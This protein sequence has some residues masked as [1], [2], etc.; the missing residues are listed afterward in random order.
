MLRVR[1]A[2][3]PQDLRCT[4]STA[5]AGP[6]RGVAAPIAALRPRQGLIRAGCSVKTGCQ[7][8]YVFY[9]VEGDASKVEVRRFTKDGAHTDTSGAVCHGPNA[10]T[11]LP[12]HQLAPRASKAA[13]RAAGALY[14]L[15]VPPAR[16]LDELRDAVAADKASGG[17][18]GFNSKDATLGPKWLQ[19]VITAIDQGRYCTSS[20]DAESVEALVTTEFPESVHLYDRLVYRAPTALLAERRRAASYGASSSLAA[21]APAA[22]AGIQVTVEQ[23]FRLALATPRGL[24]ALLHSGHQQPVFMDTTFGTNVHG[25]RVFGDAHARTHAQAHAHA[26][27]LP[28]GGPP[29]PLSAPPLPPSSLPPPPLPPPTLLHHH[30]LRHRFLLLRPS[31]PSAPVPPPPPLFSP[32]PHRLL[33]RT[34]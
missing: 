2:S 25:V 8:A 30:P 12:M 20:N 1:C 15:G 28:G 3:G 22:A 9:A 31:A 21:G 14:S 16:I 11:A 33:A 13:E 29:S 24:S 19:N 18:G 6:R 27:L 26:S 5:P 7:A 10:V 32:L 23:Q 17:G 4:P 34:R